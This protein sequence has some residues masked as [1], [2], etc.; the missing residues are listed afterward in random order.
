M[1]RSSNP[2]GSWWRYA[3]AAAATATPCATPAIAGAGASRRRGAHPLQRPPQ[4]RPIL[5]PRRHNPFR[6][7]VF[8]GGVRPDTEDDVVLELRLLSDEIAHHIDTHDVFVHR[9]GLD[10]LAV[11]LDAGRRRLQALQG[12]HHAL[13]SRR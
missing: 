12:L 2:T 4:R 5:T 10:V 8:H 11:E 9:V 6:Q 3:L 7:A 1:A 13:R